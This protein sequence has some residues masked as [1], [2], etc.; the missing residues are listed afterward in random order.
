[1]PLSLDRMCIVQR[2][3]SPEN[4]VL[5]SLEMEGRVVRGQRGAE[6][7]IGTRRRERSGQKEL[8]RRGRSG[9][10]AFHR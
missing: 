6:E 5:W 10:V 3:P 4:N 9:E 1:M 8:G 7:G 2:A